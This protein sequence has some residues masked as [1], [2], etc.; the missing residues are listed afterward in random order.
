VNGDPRQNLPTRRE[1]YEGRQ[2]EA[3]AARWDAKAPAWDHD[4][5]DP[6]CH[7][8]E[9][10]AYP[11]F[12]REVR[13]VVES[14][15]DFCSSHGLVDVGCGTGLVLAGLVSD[16]AWGVG[17]DISAGMLG[18]AR[19]KRIPRA[20][21]VHGDCFRLPELCPPAG[22]ALS[23]GVLLSHYGPQQ[24]E[25]LLRAANSTL[26]EHGFLIF[27]F[28]NEG[29]RMRHAHAAENKAYFTPETACLVARRAGFTKASIL[30]QAERRVLLLLA[31]RD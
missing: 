28:L 19:E 16:F 14:R 26:T 27:D 3:V 4:L 31:E 9:D 7:L 29:A 20:R 11:R 8:N 15:R 2:L 17:V 5:Q 22:A 13:R 30:G 21:F 25:A 6:T 18:F 24:A 23:R 12:L 10:D 1:L